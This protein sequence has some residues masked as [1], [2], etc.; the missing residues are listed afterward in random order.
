MTLTSILAIT[1]SWFIAGL[2]FYELGGKTT[3]AVIPATISS[4]TALVKT[5]YQA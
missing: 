3:N 5:L 4:N 2:A 1:P